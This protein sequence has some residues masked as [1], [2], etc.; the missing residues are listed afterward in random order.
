[1]KTHPPLVK[2]AKSGA[3]RKAKRSIPR[4]QTN[5][6][7]ALVPVSRWQPVTERG[8]L[9]LGLRQSFVASETRLLDLDEIDQVL[10]VGRRQRNLTG[11]VI[12]VFDQ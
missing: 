7:P 6:K 2:S 11:A 4:V 3:R 9:L 5:R 10:A 12:T 1:M 8:R